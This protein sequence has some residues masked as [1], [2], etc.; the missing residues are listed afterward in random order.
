MNKSILICVLVPILALSLSGCLTLVVNPTSSTSTVT[1][2]VDVPGEPA[3]QVPAT[4]VSTSQPPSFAELTATYGVLTLI[5]PPGIATGASGS[6]IARL[7]SSDAAWW[8]KTPGHLLVS[9]SDYYVLQGKSKLPQIYVF[10]AQAYAELV[11]AAFESM[12]QLNNLLD[13]GASIRADGLPA[14]PFFNE[15][16]AFA[17]NIQLL[18]FQNGHGVRFLTE[19]A[20]YAVSANN[21]DLFYEFQGLTDDG[22]FYIVAVLPTTSPLLAETNDGGAPLPPG[23]I[24]YPYFADPAADMQAYYNAVTT[25]CNNA[26]PDSFLPA[27]GQLDL[28]IHSMRIGP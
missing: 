21:S 9:L 3:T 7:D 17:S 1:Q 16:Q 14:V 6:D 26:S 10:P 19:Y 2:Q 11:P 20:Q 12:H 22:A 18:A 27:I 13:P 28:L 23:G 25:L 5:V 15:K 4:A 24:A 8:Q